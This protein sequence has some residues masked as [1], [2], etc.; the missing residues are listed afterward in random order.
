MFIIS[1][2]VQN[3]RLLGGGLQYFFLCSVR[4]IKNDTLILDR[5]L[6][7]II[8]NKLIIAS[9]SELFFMQKV[10]AF[11]VLLLACLN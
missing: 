9:Q 10:T 8:K 3:H 5:Q 4:I 1:F 7:N 11:V 2:W 6:K